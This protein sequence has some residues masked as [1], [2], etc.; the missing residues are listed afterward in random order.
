MVG[1]CIA[2]F[3]DPFP[4]AVLILLAPFPL[5]IAFYAVASALSVTLL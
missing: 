2:L 3:I 4:M 1:L 5:L